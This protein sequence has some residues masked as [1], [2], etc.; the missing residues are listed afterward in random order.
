MRSAFLVDLPTAEPREGEA[1]H[2]T[3]LLTHHQEWQG[4]MNSF[5]FHDVLELDDDLEDDPDEDDLDDDEFDQEDD[6]DE[7]PDAEDDEGETWQVG[8]EPLG[9]PALN[10]GCQLTSGSE[11]PR[12]TRI[13]QLS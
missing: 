7:D 4:L 9:F 1:R 3:D 6:G 5:G 12:L 10:P 11:L 2:R 8:E 13:F